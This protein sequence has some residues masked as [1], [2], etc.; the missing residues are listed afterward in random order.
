[1]VNK[2]NPKQQETFKRLKAFIDDKVIDTFIL[3]GYAGTG[4][5]LLIQEFAKYMESKKIKF[6]LMATTGRAAAVL[7]GKTNLDASTIHSTLY[8]FSKVVGDD[9]SIPDGASIDAYGQMVLQFEPNKTL[10]EECVYIV[11]ESSMLASEVKETGTSFAKF[12]TG[13]LLPDLLGAIGK[14]KIIFVGDP[15]Q[16]PPIDQ[17]GSPALDKHWL[18]THGRVVVQATLDEIMRTDKDNDILKV[19]EQVRNKI[20]QTLYTSTI[21]IPAKNRNNC[22]ITPDNNSLFLEYYS[23]FLQYGSKGSI[24]IAASNKLCNRLNIFF[25]KRLFPHSDQLLNVGEI[26]M[27]TQNNHIVPLVNGDLI[28]VIA[29]GNISYNVNLKFQDIRVE[30]LVTGKEYEIKMALDPIMNSKPNLTQNQ[31]RN[32]MI[33]FAINMKTKKIKPNTMEYNKAL[34]NDLYLNSLRATY[35]YVVTCHKSQGGEWDKVFLFIE[36]YMFNMFNPNEML[37]WLYTAIT[38]TK[39]H[40]YLSDNNWLE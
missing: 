28:K 2:F 26:L 13:D 17:H 14:N 16:L 25:R 5:T 12:G 7:R 34:L 21:K 30:H 37:K 23:H 22:I 4:K 35:G 24:G 6:K 8:S 36:S 20:D 18:T 9:D 33:D 40:L 27:V 15:A 32:L 19:A 10:I 31:Q 1:M 29:L 11:D 38:R 3:N 39:E